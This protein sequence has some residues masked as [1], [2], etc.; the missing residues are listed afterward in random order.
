MRR[1]WSHIILAVTS[2]VMVG[3]TFATVVTNIDSNIEYSKGKELVFRIAEPGDDG[4]PDYT[5][6][7]TVDAV[8]EVAGQMEERLKTAEISRYKVETQGLD[9][10]KVSFVQETDQQYEIIK[11]YLAFNATLAISN[12]KGTYATSEEFLNTHISAVVIVL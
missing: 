10:I 7:L 3:A 12:S 1:L 9:T 11:N 2:L 8:K 4:N 6:P 5:A